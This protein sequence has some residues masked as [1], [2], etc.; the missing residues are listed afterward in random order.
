[1]RPLFILLI[2]LAG[3][4]SFGQ[5]IVYKRNPAT[6]VLEV[7]Q[8]QGGLPT[9]SPLYKIKKNVFGYLEVENVNV[10]LNPFTQKPDY[11]SY[12]NFKPYQLPAKEI[13]ETLE[14]LNRRAEYD[15]I[16]SKP[17][18]NNTD[19]DKELKRIQEIFQKENDI[20]TSYL[21]FYSSN[22]TFPQNLKDGWYEVVKIYEN[23]ELGK[24]LQ[25]S[26]E[27]SYNLG[28]CKVINNR[29]AE[30]YENCNVF[31]IKTGFVFK[32]VR[33]E[34]S[35]AISSCKAT[36]REEGTN[37]YYS[38]YFLDNILDN[39]K[40]TSNPNF[41]YY[42]IYTSPQVDRIGNSFGV[43]IARNKTISKEELTSYSAG[44]YITLLPS[45]SQSYECNNSL[46]T[47]A[48]RQTDDNF[49]IGVIYPPNNTTWIL[50]NITLYKGSCNS[51]V[52][53]K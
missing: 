50:N 2:I 5:S 20:A 44:P 36:Y 17:Q 1:M 23:K 33:T 43:Q 13:F 25:T 16:T 32:K 47:L 49:S 29:I 26:I 41:S 14:T 31:N 7:Y 3:N 24:I 9:G 40:Q 27:Y 53:T 48:F 11:S 52:L 37:E 45:N 6:G 38:I 15:Y 19:F 12:N 34:V 39:E 46:L 51:T 10:S 21:K 35:S 22:V 42:S 30:Y 8:S 28:L 4:F 18:Q